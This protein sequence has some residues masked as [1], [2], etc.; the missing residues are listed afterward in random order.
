MA[1]TY[2]TP[3]TFSASEALEFDDLQDV[4]DNT[5]AIK[6]GDTSLDKVTN[7]GAFI[8]SGRQNNALA[9]GAN[10]NLAVGAGVTVIRVTPDAGG[11]STITG[12][13]G[14]ADGRLV[15]VVNVT[16]TAFTFKNNDAG[17]TAGNKLILPGN[18]DVAM[19]AADSLLFWYDSTSS[20]WRGINYA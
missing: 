12:L 17:S 14:G 6:Q 10:N 15:L 18:A 11:T 4:A 8:L 5:G 20:V 16:T 1:F 19:G 9:A 7:T 13:T 3:P 2:T